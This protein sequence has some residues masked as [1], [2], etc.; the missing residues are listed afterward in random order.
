M[1]GILKSK[2]MRIFLVLFFIFFILFFNLNTSYSQTENRCINY[3]AGIGEMEYYNNYFKNIELIGIG[4]LSSLTQSRYDNLKISYEIDRNN[5]TSGNGSLK[6]SLLRNGILDSNNTNPVSA[7]YIFFRDELI[8]PELYDPELKLLSEYR[9][10]YPKAGDRIRISFDFKTQGVS[11]N[12]YYR[13]ENAMWDTLGGHYYYRIIYNTS[14]NFLNWQRFSFTT[15]VID[16]IKW[17][18]IRALAFVVYLTYP[19]INTTSRANF[20]IDNVQVFIDRY[21]SSTNQWECIRFPQKQNTSSLKFAEVFSINLLPY[22]NDWLY[23]YLNT[24]LWDSPNL[25]HGLRIYF[26]DNSYKLADY[27][28]PGNFVF[29]EKENDPGSF[30]FKNRGRVHVPLNFDHM[31]KR[32]K[33]TSTTTWW[34]GDRNLHITPN[35]LYPENFLLSTSTNKMVSDLYYIRSGGYHELENVLN[36]KNISY[37]EY[38]KKINFLKYVKDFYNKDIFW[39]IRLDAP[40]SN[41]GLWRRSRQYSSFEEAKYYVVR[42]MYRELVEEL[43]N[44]GKKVFANFGYSSIFIPSGRYEGFDKFLDGFMNEGFLIDRNL[45]FKSSQQSHQ[46]IQSVVENFKN[47]YSILMVY[48]NKSWCNDNNTTTAYLVSSF[49]LVNNPGV[50]ISF[51]MPKYDIIPSGSTRIDS[52]SFICR[53]SSMY[54]PLGNP[55]NVNSIEELV[56]T[57]TPNYSEGALYRRRYEKGLVLLNTSDRLTFTYT[58]SSTTEPFT[59]YKDHLGNNYIF[60]NNSINLEISPRSGLILYNPNP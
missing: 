17:N 36:L 19:N 20:W 55:E 38:Y 4:G 24:D 42:R 48:T 3:L 16:N 52:S 59:N 15:S 50:Y 27:N 10:Y 32:V 51:E 44:I 43:K 9:D 33:D 13:I 18:G 31:I 40:N 2:L 30:R 21:N 34:L 6:I 53:T 56:V 28:F 57:S 23:F 54:L 49:Y 39:A 25:S 37:M 12:M 58:L 5:K 8:L 29:R 11:N 14:T 46:E 22:K 26:H 1:T 41:M 60:N 47:K 45:S 35:S 7:F